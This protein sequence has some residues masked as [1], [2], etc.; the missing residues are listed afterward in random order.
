MG[1]VMPLSWE[2]FLSTPAAAFMAIQL[3]ALTVLNIA[4]GDRGSLG[5]AQLVPEPASMMLLSGGVMTLGLIR[6]KRR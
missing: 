3:D 6:R 5:N 4:D 1:P 2:E